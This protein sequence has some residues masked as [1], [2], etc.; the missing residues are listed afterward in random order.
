[1]LIVIIVLFFVLIY[2]NSSIE[3]FTNFTA[4]VNK[5]LPEN[6]IIKNDHYLDFVQNIKNNLNDTNEGPFKTVTSE[7]QKKALDI[8]FKLEPNENPI[9]LATINALVDKSTPVL[10]NTSKNTSCVV[11]ADNLCQH[12]NPYQFL[13]DT[14]NTFPPK[15]TKDSLYENVQLTKETNLNCWNRM[16]NCCKQNLT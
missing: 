9:E 5:K 2:Y 8:A 6:F 7:A 11:K 10:Y 16:Y 12:T 14:K 15:W 4:F 1:M 13:V 3:H